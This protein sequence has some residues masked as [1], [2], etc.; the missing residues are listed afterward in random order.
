MLKNYLKIAWRNL[1]KYKG[2][3]F[4]NVLGLAVGVAACVLIFRYVSHELSYDKFHDNSD[5]IYRVTYDT[6]KRHVAVTPSVASPMLQ[7]TFPEVQA[8]VRIFAAGLFSPVVLQHGKNVFEESS[9][10]YADSS[11][12]DVF[13]FKVLAG[14]SKKALTRPNTMVISSDLARKY[15]GSENP[16]GR[17]LLLNNEQEYE[18]TAVIEEMPSNSHFQFDIITSLTSIQG[19]DQLTDEE[20]RGQQFLTYVILREGVS[21]SELEQKINAYAHQRFPEE[22]ESE[23]RLLPLTDI[24]LYSNLYAEVQPQGDIRY[25]MAA[26]AIAILILIIACINYMNLAT[27]RSARRSREVGIRK[28]LGSDRR[29]LIGQFYGESALLVGL[30]LLLAMFLVELFLPLFNQMTGQWLEAGYS[31]PGL[32]GMLILTGVSVTFLAG[33]YPA[34]VLSGFNPASVLKGTGTLDEGNV[35]LRKTL[36]V[37]QFAVSIFLIV[38]TLV[39][40]QQVNF[41]QDKELGFKKD[42]VIALTSYNE[43]ESR[44]EAFK[45]ELM[46]NPGVENVTMASDTPVDIVAGF[47]I[48]VEGV[49]EDPNLV[50]N[51][52][53]VHPEFNQTMNIDILAGR[54]L[55]PGDYTAVNPEEE[56]P[57]FAFLVNEAAVRTFGLEPEEIV[58]RKASMDERNGIVVG[59]VEDFHFAPLHREIEPLVIFPQT[60]FNKLLVSFLSDNTRQTLEQTREVWQSLFPALP[61]EYEF[62]DQEYDALYRQEQRVG[63]IFSSFAFLAI[64]VASLGLFGL[65]S[66]MVE[67]R[68]KEI[69]VRKVFG[70]TIADIVGLFSRDFVLL[71]LIGFAL[72][73]PVSWYVMSQWLQGFAYRITIGADIFLLAGGAALVIALLTVAWQSIKAAVANPVDSLKSE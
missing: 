51:G 46:Q 38:G 30:A 61:F 15:F 48:D 49:E 43:V 8:G 41:I 7:R 69:G 33:S 73:V 64:F 72:V 4:I 54:D 37:F 6:P 23:F 34:V 18:V 55:R 24:H 31:D 21:A 39:I 16:V 14:D 53:V 2:Y 67:Q 65:A 47:S 32:W 19:W 58:G 52:L 57:V 70:A 20:M 44:F 17:T 35:N 28:V 5:R 3:S 59:V 45:S 62:L 36:V 40:Y 50:I 25:V 11:F 1:L 9:F 63:N 12:F 13:S 10:A 26:S 29:N 71:V 22:R 27:A 42:N 68:T 56:E 60:G 66:Y